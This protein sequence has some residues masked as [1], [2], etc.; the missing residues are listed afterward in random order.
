MAS[1]ACIG[2]VVLCSI[3]QTPPCSSLLHDFLTVQASSACSPVSISR[4]QPSSTNVGSATQMAVSTTK[5]SPGDNV[6]RCSSSPTNRDGLYVLSLE[7]GA[8]EPEGR[9]RMKRVERMGDRLWTSSLTGTV[10][11]LKGSQFHEVDLRTVGTY[12]SSKSW[13]TAPAL[14]SAR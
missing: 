9:V 8:S 12:P 1:N 10:L 4:S 3:F 11:G 13:A 2:Y 7:G 6:P 5:V 14:A